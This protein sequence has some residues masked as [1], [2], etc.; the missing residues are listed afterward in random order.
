LNELPAL[1]NTKARIAK[2]RTPRLE[3]AHGALL[4][5]NARVQR[6]V[7]VAAWLVVFAAPR[8]IAQER[9]APA[10]P[11]VLDDQQLLRK[12]VWSTLGPSGALDATLASAFEQ[13]REAP[14][15]WSLDATGY[16][17]RW[18]SEFAASAIGN[19][20]KYTVAHFLKHDPS[21][22]RC[23]CVGIRAR[24][25][26]AILGPFKARTAEGDWVFSPA[27]LAALAAENVV[28]AASWYPEPHGVRDGLAHAGT[29]V[30][31]KMG[32]NVFREFV[33]DRK[34]KTPKR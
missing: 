10:A 29:G 9:P 8:C 11:P 5:C 17:Q 2:S 16:G 18:A 3:A 28:P 33:Y 12:Y 31:A 4:G 19:T 7:L 20:T 34:K 24:L 21:F 1:V 14:R 13:W 23:E 22:V 25:G 32:V 15:E 27:T 6:A 30:L 26:H